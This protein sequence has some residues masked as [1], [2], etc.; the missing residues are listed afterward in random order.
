MIFALSRATA[1][2][3]RGLLLQLSE[4]FSGLAVEALVDSV[5]GFRIDLLVEQDADEHFVELLQIR[6]TNHI[7]PAANEAM[8][9]G[10]FE[11]PG[12]GPPM[13]VGGI[14]RAA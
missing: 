3:D 2:T 14:A 8:G 1:A 10:A 7:D 13:R 6:L 9:I 4:K 5:D 11:Q 12:G